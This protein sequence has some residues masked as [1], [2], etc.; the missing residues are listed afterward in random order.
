MKK[1]GTGI[2]L[3]GLLLTGLVALVAGQDAGLGRLQPL[4]VDLQQAVPIEVSFVLQGAE[5]QTVTVPMTLDLHLQVGLS[6]SLTPV[7]SV[8]PVGPALVSVSQ[9]AAQTEPLQDNSGLLYTVELF[10]GIE[11]VQLRT[12]A[13]F[14]DEMQ[15]IGE[16]R[17]VSD[18]EMQAFRVNFVV[19]IYD[20]DGRILDAA[21][22][23]PTLQVIR[24]GQTSPFTI[25]TQAPM[26]Q[27]GRY[28]IQFDSD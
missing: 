19:T 25:L 24:P 20:E 7:V 14:A 22:G 16:V 13:D 26:A 4:L 1:I 3:A 6:S 23:Y 18:E 11:L 10:E 28:L 17:N 9:L 5:P 21:T 2:A 8:G 12:D 15:L 27:V